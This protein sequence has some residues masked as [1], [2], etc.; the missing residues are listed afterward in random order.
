MPSPNPLSLVKRNTHV[1]FNRINTVSFFGRGRGGG[2][3]GWKEGE[4]NIFTK[5][6][7]LKKKSA[8]VGG[9]RCEKYLF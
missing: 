2:G 9:G 8:W 5:N 6:P 3:W 1:A 4:V 7:N